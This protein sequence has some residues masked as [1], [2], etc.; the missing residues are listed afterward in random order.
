MDSAHAKPVP[1][2]NFRNASS[3]MAQAHV[4]S[5]CIMSCGYAFVLKFNFTQFNVLFYI[6]SKI[7]SDSS[8]TH[9]F[10]PAW[11]HAFFATGLCRASRRYGPLPSLALTECEDKGVDLIV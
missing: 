9:N 10:A 6:F 2:Q 8:P 11:G 4:P 7:K 5:S 1:G 3:S